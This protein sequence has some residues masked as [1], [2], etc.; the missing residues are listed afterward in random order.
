MHYRHI[1]YI[2]M[3][4]F[5]HHGRVTKTKVT[6]AIGDRVVLRYQPLR[7][8][9]ERDFAG[10]AEGARAPARECSPLPHGRSLTAVVN[11][12]LRMR[13]YARHALDHIQGNPSSSVRPHVA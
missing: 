8:T 11:Q 4:W 3:K 10:S 5:L 13:S 9:V 12:C 6:F 2:C 1:R 7:E